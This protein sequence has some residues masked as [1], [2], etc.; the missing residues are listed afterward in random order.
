MYGYVYLTRDL[1]NNKIYVGQ[2]KSSKFLGNKY[3]GSG[4]IISKIVQKL[5]RENKDLNSIFIV[6]LVEECDSRETLDE[7]EIY[8]IKKYDAQNSEI[9]YNLLEGG[10]GS[11]GLIH[12]EETKMWIGECSKKLWQDKEHRLKMSLLQ[13]GDANVSKRA[14]VRKKISETRMGHNVSKE[15][16]QKQSKKLKRQIWINKDKRNKIIKWDERDILDKFLAEGWQKGRYWSEEVKNSMREAKLGNKNPQYNK[17]P[18]NY[19]KS[20]TKETKLKMSESAKK[21]AETA[22]NYA[23]PIRY[24]N[25][26]TEY[27]SIAE[28]HRALNISEHIIRC[29]LKINESYKGHH[30][31]HM[32]QNNSKK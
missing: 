12:S 24:L 25:N 2:K 3:V 15:Q 8:W 23:S 31:V 17:K 30:F 6:E 1:R 4:T 14:E 28:A 7:R 29:S 5:L 21:R 19:G 20:H 13:S 27:R 26:D 22:L 16:R 32:S 10:G 18:P 9:G 11:K